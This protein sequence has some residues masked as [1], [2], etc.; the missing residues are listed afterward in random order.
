MDQAMGCYGYFVTSVLVFSAISVGG[1]QR[2]QR[3]FITPVC[4]RCLACVRL[5][6]YILVESRNGCWQ[7]EDRAFLSL[8]R[9]RVGVWN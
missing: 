6:S 5:F 9:S 3:F 8:C 7:Q 1:R 4:K 2:F